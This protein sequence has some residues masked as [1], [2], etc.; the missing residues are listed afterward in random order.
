MEETE[1]IEGENSEIRYYIRGK[2][3]DTVK[4]GNSEKNKS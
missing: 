1:I 3:E 4:M 2:T